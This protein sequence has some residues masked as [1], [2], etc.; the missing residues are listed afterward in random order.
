MNKVISKIVKVFAILAF[1]VGLFLFIASINKYGSKADTMAIIGI[2]SVV[3]SVFLA[4]LSVL[5]EAAC[6]YIE[7]NKK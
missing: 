5:V 4:C 7:K 3:S 6:I 2:S 1:V